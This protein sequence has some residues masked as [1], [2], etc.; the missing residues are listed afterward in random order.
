MTGGYFGERRNLL[1]IFSIFF[2]A[3]SYG[4]AFSG[5]NCADTYNLFLG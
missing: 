4:P 2:C 1:A 3:N 5:T